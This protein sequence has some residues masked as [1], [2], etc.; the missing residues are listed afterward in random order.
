MEERFILSPPA[1]SASP[2]PPACPNPSILMW[3]NTSALSDYL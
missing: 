1:P 3:S 2:A